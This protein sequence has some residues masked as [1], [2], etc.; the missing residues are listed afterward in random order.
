MNGIAQEG[1]HGDRTH[2]FVIPD[3]LTTDRLIEAMDRLKIKV[4]S[5]EKGESSLEDVFTLLAHTG[6]KPNK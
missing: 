1:L 6:G 4:Q 2:V 5:I 3:V